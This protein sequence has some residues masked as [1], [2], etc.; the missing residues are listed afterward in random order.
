MMTCQKFWRL[1]DKW[2][3]GWRKIRPGMQEAALH[4][5]DVEHRTHFLFAISPSRNVSLCRSTNLNLVETLP[6]EK[7]RAIAIYHAR[8][9]SCSINFTHFA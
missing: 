4:H 6:T 5:V 1:S 2:T 7:I 8:R 3:N 9:T